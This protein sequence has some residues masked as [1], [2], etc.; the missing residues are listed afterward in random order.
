[1]PSSSHWRLMVSFSVPS[2]THP[3]VSL[4]GLLHQKV[5][6]H[7]QLSDGFQ[8]GCLFRLR[9]LFL[10]GDFFCGF[11]FFK[12]HRCFSK[13]AA[14]HVRSWFGF[15]WC[16]AAISPN[17]RSPWSTS[18]TNFAL[19]SAVDFRFFMPDHCLSYFYSIKHLLFLQSRV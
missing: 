3:F 15:I 10:T 6:F 1:M 16:S 17:S 14:F 4:M 7:R 2:K 11:I 19:K 8:H 18:K 12:Y 9:F 5:P 13:K